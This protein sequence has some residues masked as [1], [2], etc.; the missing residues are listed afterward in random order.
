MTAIIKTV[1]MLDESIV[2]TTSAYVDD[3]YVNE[4]IMCTDAVRTK[5]QSFGLISKRLKRLLVMRS[6]RFLSHLILT[7]SA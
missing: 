4:D 2:K 3:I 7:L 6:K 1:L 5:L